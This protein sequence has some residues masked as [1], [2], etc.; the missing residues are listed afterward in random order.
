M[1]VPRNAGA[2]G[3]D[4]LIPQV[5]A[6]PIGDRCGLRVSWAWRLGKPESRKGPKGQGCGAWARPEASMEYLTLFWSTC[7]ILCSLCKHFMNRVPRPY[8]QSCASMLSMS[9]VP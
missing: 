8:C 1:F 3:E 7:F 5:Q 9:E 6:G 2:G 4:R